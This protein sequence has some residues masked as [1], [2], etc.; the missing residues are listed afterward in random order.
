MDYKWLKHVRALPSHSSNDVLK[1][2]YID[3]NLKNLRKLIQNLNDLTST[4]TPH[5]EEQQLAAELLPL[6]QVRDELSWLNV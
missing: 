6:H 4:I 1:V 5:A 3:V 2:D